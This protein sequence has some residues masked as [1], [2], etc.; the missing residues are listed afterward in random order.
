VDHIWSAD[1][2]K[3]HFDELLHER[4]EADETHR[5]AV[6]QRFAAF[7][8]RISALQSGWHDRFVSF[9]GA[10][11]ARIASVAKGVDDLRTTVGTSID[12]LRTSMTKSLDELRR[13][14]YIGL[15]VAIAGQLLIPLLHR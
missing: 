12:V 7:D 5:L 4:R 14:V 11:D 3:Q 15:G 9:E 8:Q 13:L 10:V 6:E 2:L 1:T